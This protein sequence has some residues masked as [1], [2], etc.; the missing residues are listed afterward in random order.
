MVAVHASIERYYRTLIAD[1]ELVPLSMLETLFEES[2]SLGLDK[3]N[4]PVVFKKETPDMA[5]AISMGKGLLKTFY[6][7][8]DLAGMEIV[9]VEVPLSATL[10]TDTGGK[11]D[12]N[13][14]GV[15]DLLLRDANG[16]LLVVDNKTSKQAKSQ[17]AVDDDLQFSSYSYLLI[18]NKYVFPCAEVNCRFDVLR[19]LKTPKLEHYFTSR[20][21]EHRKRFSKIAN[22]VLAGI[23]SRLF[24]PVKNW[25][26]SDC[27]Y[28]DA[29]ADW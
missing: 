13:L 20:T 29:C 24:I 16:N 1:G 5:S 10:F 27:Q 2:L 28:S 19:K 25:M 14:I 12:I 7:N 15:I 26:C 21:A 22:A 4:L 18:A 23:E 8:V 9:G 3:T 11:T 17:D 6:E